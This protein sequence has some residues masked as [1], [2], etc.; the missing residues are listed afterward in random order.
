MK[1]K[2]LGLLSGALLTWALTAGIASASTVTLDV[3]GTITDVGN[4]T[5]DVVLDVVGGQAISG[6]GSINIL[7]MS[8]TPLVLI[9]PSTPGNEGSGGS[10][11]FRDN[12]GTDIGYTD[13][14]YPLINGLLFDVGTATASWG[15]YP[16]FA[17]GS[18]WSLFSGKVAG[19]YYYD[20][21]GT[22]SVAAVPEPSTWA[23]MILGFAGVGFMAYRRKS[24]PAL[25]AA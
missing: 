23:M 13:T 16:L 10:V 14:A 20:E 2:S 1:I 3:T 6:T 25:M 24:N 19:T 9:T 12:G 17:F 8:S 4:F 15:Q 22:V 21:S 7:G 18:D 5:A 11:A